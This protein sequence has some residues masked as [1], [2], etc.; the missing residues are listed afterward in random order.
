MHSATEFAGHGVGLS[1]VKRIVQK[2]DGA[3]RVE[4][5]VNEGACFRRYLPATA[6]AVAPQAAP[7][8]MGAGA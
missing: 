7:T 4:A 2:H 1:I 8:P 3:I 6:C 5:K